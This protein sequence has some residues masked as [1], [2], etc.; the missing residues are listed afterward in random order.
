M[1][2]HCELLEKFLMDVPRGKAGM[3]RRAAMDAGRR[4]QSMRDA[5]GRVT[6]ARDMANIPIDCQKNKQ[7]SRESIEGGESC[8]KEKGLEW[9]MDLLPEEEL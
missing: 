6:A 2:V 8:R 4:W 7:E 9:M 5:N 3:V 1:G